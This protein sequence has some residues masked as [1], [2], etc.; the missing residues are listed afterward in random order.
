MGTGTLSP[1]GTAIQ[2]TSNS[3]T[4]GGG[5]YFFVPVPQAA[6]S[7]STNPLNPLPGLPASPASTSFGSEIS[8][9]SGAVQTS[10]DLV[11][12]QSQ[13][14][15]RGLQLDYNSLW[16]DPRPIVH[17]GYQNLP[18][19]SANDSLTASLSTVA[20]L[21]VVAGSAGPGTV[22][23]GAA[24]AVAEFGMPS[25][26]NYW[27]L[28]AGGGPIDVAL[29][30]DLSSQR[31]GVYNLELSVGLTRFVPGTNDV[32]GG[33]S[34]ES[35]PVVSVNTS[36]S[37]FGS[38]WSLGG[39]QQVVENSDQSLLLVDGDGTTLLFEPP[40]TPGGPYVDPAGDFSTLVELPDG[41]FRRTLTDQTVYNFNF[42]GQLASMRDRN[43]NQTQYLYD[44][45]GRLTTI[46]DPV[47]LRT[48]FSYT[49]NLVTGI[50]DPDQHT[51]V[52]KYDG[53]G[54]LV[55]VI[56]PDQSERQWAYDANHL[57]TV[58]TDQRGNRDQDFYDFA[59][60]G[61]S[62]LRSDGSTVQVSPAEVNGLYPPAQTAAPVNATFPT[63]GA[64]AQAVVQIADPNGNVTTEMLDQRGQEESS[65]G[66]GRYSRFG[67][68]QF[69]R[70]DRPE[71]Q[72][73]GQSDERCLR[74]ERQSDQHAGFPRRRLPGPERLQPRLDV[75]SGSWRPRRR[76][77]RRQWRRLSDLIAIS[78]LG[79]S[80]PTGQVLLNVKNGSGQPTGT[81]TAAQTC[82]R[83]TVR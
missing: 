1:D 74:R 36:A 80:K 8:L 50:T 35:M 56:N 12:Y 28:P 64:P 47:G 40:T 30:A 29:Q 2:G 16:A 21:P 20:G 70:L 77:W 58:D 27:K 54:N 44:V 7:L 69:P 61:V 33:F 14:V 55:A 37:A 45:A 18:A 23:T 82:P 17:F 25:G 66:C 42:Q 72:R 39:L 9:Y 48:T 59:G 10:D 83:W 31:T 73:P 78:G 81:S 5:L 53:A 11:T 22:T 3:L 51:T 52:L 49:G 79:S 15:V 68:P 76:R 62:S 43:G 4:A 60:R 63:A 38:G 19:G 75:H 46:L 6:S 32:T 13:G 34:S 71:Y 65:A 67:D 57:L 24:G 41:T 26:E